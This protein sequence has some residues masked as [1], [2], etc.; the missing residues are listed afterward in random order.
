[1][2]AQKNGIDE[3][4]CEET[5]NDVLSVFCFLFCVLISKARGVDDTS[6][7][8]YIVSDEIISP[9]CLKSEMT[10]STHRQWKTINHLL[11]DV[12]MQY[13]EK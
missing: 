12:N 10:Q 6:R 5:G 13:Y 3:D 8:I 1:M 9:L 4:L 11:K 2:S 7:Y